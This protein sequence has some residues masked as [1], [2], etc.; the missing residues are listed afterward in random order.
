MV[1][2]VFAHRQSDY[3][4]SQLAPSPLLHF[5]SLALEE[6]FYI[7]WPFVLLVV[8]GVRRRIRLVALSTIGVL[9]IVSLVGC[10]WLTP[11][12]HSWA[13]FSLP[14]RAW[15]LLSGAGLALAGGALVKIPGLVRAVMAWLGLGAV[16][17]AALSF[18]DRTRFP[19]YT[20]LLPVLATVVIVAGASDVTRGGPGKL[21]S[22]RPL[23]WIGQ[24]SYAIYLWHW[25]ALVLCRAKFG[26]LS[27]WQSAAVLVT[28]G[29]NAQVPTT[30]S[31]LPL[32]AAPGDPSGPLATSIPPS[33]SASTTSIASTTAQPNAAVQALLTANADTLSKVC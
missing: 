15:E 16:V 5:W 10:V 28:P 27:S 4:A 12:Q 14:T 30:T 2:N 24:R 21:L 8:T 9:W 13:F 7:V 25:P 32:G 11:R 17:F 3:F 6:Q 20:A 22:V 1:N 33:A 29:A 31:V 26:A 19:G 23:M 18:N